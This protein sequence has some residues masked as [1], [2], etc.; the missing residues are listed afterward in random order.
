MP[1]SC[2]IVQG[3]TNKANCSVGISIHFSPLGN[4]GEP[5]CIKLVDTHCANLIPLAVFQFALHTLPKRVSKG[6]M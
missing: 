2:C 4:K 6:F 1:S 5:M 3:C